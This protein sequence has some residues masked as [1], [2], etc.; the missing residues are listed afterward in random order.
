LS[1]VAVT[2]TITYNRKAQKSKKKNAG[3]KQHYLLRNGS[4]GERREKGA[5]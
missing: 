2:G 5:E 1:P 3:D 4:E